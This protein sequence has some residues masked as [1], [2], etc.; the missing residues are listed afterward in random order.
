MY[1]VLLCVRD[2]GSVALGWR[3]HV[4]VENVGVRAILWDHVYNFLGSLFHCRECV[5]KEKNAANRILSYQ[6]LLLGETK[7]ESLEL[8]IDDVV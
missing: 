3:M 4:K 6:I 2:S 8:I 7:N 1:F 5:G